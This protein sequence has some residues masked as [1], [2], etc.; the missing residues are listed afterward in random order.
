MAAGGAPPALPSLFPLLLILVAAL[1]PQPA[2]ADSHVEPASYLQRA[3]NDSPMHDAARKGDTAEVTKLL[4]KGVVD[5]NSQRESHHAG[6]PACAPCR[7]VAV[8][9][10]VLTTAAPQGWCTTSTRPAFAACR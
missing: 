10:S 4:A 7:P 2:G 1:R 8:L 9:R 6:L 5:C 3:S